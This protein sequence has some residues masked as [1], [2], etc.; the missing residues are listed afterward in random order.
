[1]RLSHSGFLAAAAGSLVLAG[2]AEAA[3]TGPL[4]F[5]A[6]SVI[7]DDFIGTLNVLVVDSLEVALT[8]T[9]ADDKLAD[10]AVKLDGSSLVVRRGMGASGLSR[11]LD[12]AAYPVIDLRVPA[13]FTAVWRPR[14]R[15]R[16]PGLTTM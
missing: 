4:T 6:T 5:N 8:I 9:G 11:G 2:A 12:L 13:S 15:L 14:S 1:M 16:V 3:T 10:I 7:V